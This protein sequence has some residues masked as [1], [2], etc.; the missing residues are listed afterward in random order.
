MLLSPEGRILST[1]KV[2][3]EIISTP[4]MEGYGLVPGEAVPGDSRIDLADTG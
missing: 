4:N 2:V 3:L 1:T